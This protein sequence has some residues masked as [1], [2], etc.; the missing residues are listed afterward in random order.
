MKTVAKMEPRRSLRLAEK[1]NRIAEGKT[2]QP[3]QSSEEVA[4]PA[5]PTIYL[6]CDALLLACSVVVVL[7]SCLSF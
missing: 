2:V 1:R 3:R 4:I 6:N 7:A 5:S